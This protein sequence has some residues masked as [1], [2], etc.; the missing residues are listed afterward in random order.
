MSRALGCFALLWTALGITGQ[1]ALCFVC[2]GGSLEPKAQSKSSPSH[3]RAG[4]RGA[5][6]AENTCRPRGAPGVSTLTGIGGLRPRPLPRE[7]PMVG[8]E[9]MSPKPEFAV[10][11]P[12]RAAF[13]QNGGS[14]QALGAPESRANP[15]P[16]RPKRLSPVCWPR[17]GAFP[18]V[19]PRRS[20]LFTHNRIALRRMTCAAA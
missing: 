18:G 4:Q 12:F 7:Q 9:R 14:P 19:Q 11:A 17:P 16:G 6:G 8:N 15:H 20:R 1:S 10:S 3:Q 13:P 2:F 5:T